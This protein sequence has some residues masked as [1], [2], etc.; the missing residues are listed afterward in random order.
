MIYAIA[1]IRVRDAQALG[2]YREKASDALAKHGG[3]VEGASKDLTAIDGA[4]DL[5]DMTA[6]LSFPD[7]ASAE[8]W[9]GDPELAAVHDLRRQGGQSDIY[10]VG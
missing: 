6:V 8:A 4:P 9:I 7:K 5:P 10:I 1:E 2:A 3:K